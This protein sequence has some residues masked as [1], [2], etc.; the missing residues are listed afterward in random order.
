MHRN[1][2]QEIFLCFTVAL[3][4]MLF[5]ILAIEYIDIRSSRF[6]RQHLECI[7]IINQYDPS[8]TVEEASEI[9]LTIHNNI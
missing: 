5:I 1:A 8:L 3:I 4:I 2:K 6:E 9:C 7:I